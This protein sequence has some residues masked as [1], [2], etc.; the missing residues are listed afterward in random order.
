MLMEGSLAGERACGPA[1]RA[2]ATARRARV[3]SLEARD[4]DG[5]SWHGG[6]RTGVTEQEGEAAFSG[7]RVLPR[8]REEEFVLVA[9]TGFADQFRVVSMVAR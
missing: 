3:S 6:L 8:S 1:Y 5:R 2:S 9:G 4:F 7:A